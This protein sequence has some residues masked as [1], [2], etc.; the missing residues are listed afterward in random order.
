MFLG[1]LAALRGKD[2]SRQ[3]AKTP[4]KPLGT[5]GRLKVFPNSSQK[6]FPVFV[7]CGLVPFNFF[8]L[9]WLCGTTPIVDNAGLI[10]RVPADRG[11]GFG[12]RRQSLLALAAGGLGNGGRL[13]VRA[14]AG[15]PSGH[16]S[17][18]SSASHCENPSDLQLKPE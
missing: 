12:S 7:L 1:A 10:K 15:I 14:F 17:A 8:S 6:H 2:F 4:R 18:D 9:A 13:R 3:D 5:H 16:A 11:S